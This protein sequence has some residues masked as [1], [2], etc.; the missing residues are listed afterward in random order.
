MIKID[1]LSFQY[2]KRPILTEINAVFE[3]G[4]LYAVVGPNGCGKTTLI[5]LMARLLRPDSGAVYLEGKQVETFSSIAYA[6]KVA[7]MPQERTMP[8]VSVEECVTNAR[9]PYLDLTRKLTV[10]DREAVELALRQTETERFRHCRMTELSGGERQRVYL[11]ML[12]AQD[13]PYVLLD[14]PTTYLDIAHQFAVMQQ[15]SAMRDA[16][17]CVIAVLHDLSLAFQY[18]DEV[19]VL[20]K[21]KACGFDKPENIVSQGLIPLAFG[22]QCKKIED[23]YLFY[24]K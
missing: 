11:A 19:L 12:L 2:G 23:I 15:L 10:K 8:Q 5:R 9:Y 14:E 6:R 7:L 20:D 18:C 24:Q 16:G 4:K 17:K 22:V 3:T 21:G 1:H 13:T